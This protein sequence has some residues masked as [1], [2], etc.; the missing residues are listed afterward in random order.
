VGCGEGGNLVNVFGGPTTRPRLVVGLDRFEAK[1]AFARQH[2]RGMQFVCADATALPFRAGAFNAVLCRD[3][4]H[5][6]ED[7]ESAIRELRRVAR[8]DAAVWVVEPN[9]RNPLVKLLALVRPHERGQLANTPQ[10]LR[11]LLTKYFPEVEVELRQPMPIHRLLLHYQFGA[12]RLGRSVVMGA[13]LDAGEMV[14]RTVIPRRWWAYI[15]A[16]ARREQP[17]AS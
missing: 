4:L 15:I 5:H 2:A 13:L 12:P 7:R 9:G 11:R 14:L 8:E 16:R 10:S 3:V 17:A 1:L 6:L